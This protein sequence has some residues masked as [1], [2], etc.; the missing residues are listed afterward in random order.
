MAGAGYKLFNTGDVLTAAQV[1]TY[2][3]EQSVMVF[4]DATARTTALSGVL[5]EGMITY[6]KS[7]DKVYKYT[8]SAWV[9]V[10]GGSSPL[11]T[12]G[13]LYTYS[14]TDARLG[15]G[16]N[17]QVLTAD[18]TASTG[19]KWAD[20]ASGG[21]MTLLSTTTLSGTSTSISITPTGYNSLEIHVNDFQWASQ[22]NFNM[23]FNN[24]TTTNNYVGVFTEWRAVGSNVLS[25]GSGDANVGLSYYDWASGDNDNSAV[26]NVYNPNGTTVGKTGRVAINGLAAGGANYLYSRNQVFQYRGTS[27]ISSVQFKSTTSLSGGTVLI[28]GVK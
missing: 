18:S 22:A 26:I 5:A 21:G 7:D 10:G 9:E 24:D 4:A 1:N 17:G 14:T 13:D 19:L 8:G 3:Q 20:A 15:V 11:T 28:Y 25:T 12:K 6:L 2:L 27:A 23:T 16:T